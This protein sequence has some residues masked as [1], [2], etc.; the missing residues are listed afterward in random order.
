MPSPVASFQDTEKNVT[1]VVY[2]LDYLRDNVFLTGGGDKE[3]S[4]HSFAQFVRVTESDD[5]A[6]MNP[7]ESRAS[8]RHTTAANMGHSPNE[9][10]AS[11]TLPPGYY[12]ALNA[13]LMLRFGPAQGGLT[14]TDIIR[15]NH[16]T[17]SSVLHTSGSCLY[18]FDLNTLTSRFVF[19]CSTWLNS[20]CLV[21]DLVIAADCNGKRCS[22]LCHCHC[23]YHICL[24]TSGIIDIPRISTLD[25][26]AHFEIVSAPLEL[27]C[28]DNGFLAGDSG[29]GVSMYELNEATARFPVPGSK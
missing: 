12:A 14:K 26:T 1:E 18:Q 20:F 7:P 10:A 24:F 5:N 2:A 3:V 11:R 15:I 13:F 28:F 9:S 8:S 16:N 22:S 6:T 23:A 17:Y 25:N 29:G 4:K 19:Q 27:L 21:D